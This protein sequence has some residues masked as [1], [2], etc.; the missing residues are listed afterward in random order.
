VDAP[1]PFTEH[2]R[3]TRVEVGDENACAVYRVTPGTAL[4]VTSAE[5]LAAV[6]VAPVGALVGAPG[7]AGAVA[8]LTVIEIVPV[9]VRAG[10][11]A[12]DAVT[13]KMVVASVV[14]GVPEITPVVGSKSNP[15]GSV[16]P[17]IA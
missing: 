15:V 4:Q 6:T 14:L 17:E 1:V 11:E 7:E 3:T 5:P 12:S 10:A 9:V 2:W 8:A 13:V 16:P